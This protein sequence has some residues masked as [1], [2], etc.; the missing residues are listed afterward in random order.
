MSK[1]TPRNG[2][3]RPAAEARGVTLLEALDVLIVHLGDDTLSTPKTERARA[4]LRA[5]LR[6]SP[7]R[8]TLRDPFFCPTGCGFL[9]ADDWDGHFLACL[10]RRSTEI[11]FSEISED[12]R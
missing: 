2:P 11:W 5:A 9:M 3:R 10:V 4:I 7:R 1:R 6:P 12:G 8:H